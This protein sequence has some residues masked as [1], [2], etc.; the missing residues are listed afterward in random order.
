M[1]SK[2]NA[3]VTTVR[4]IGKTYK[5]LE[6]D[7]LDNQGLCEDD[8][9]QIS[10]RKDM[11][12]ESWADTVIHECA[13]AIDFNLKLG[14]TERQVHCIGSGLWALLADNPELTQRICAAALKPREK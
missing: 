11:P 2:K 4:I 6:V 7:N 12:I 1:A 13:H 10:I 8:K 5:L 14:L 9:Q 3:P